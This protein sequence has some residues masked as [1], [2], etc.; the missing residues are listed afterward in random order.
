MSTSQYCSGRNDQF[1]LPVRSESNNVTSRPNRYWQLCCCRRLEMRSM[2]LIKPDCFTHTGFIW[3]FT[4]AALY[5]VPALGYESL[6]TTLQH[7]SNWHSEQIPS[8][9]LS[10]VKLSHSVKVTEG[11]GSW[12]V[13][14]FSDSFLQMTA[15][16]SIWRA[17]SSNKRHFLELFLYT[18]HCWCL[19]VLQSTNVIRVLFFLFSNTTETFLS[20]DWWGEVV[21]ERVTRLRLFNT[22]ISNW[23]AAERYINSCVI[24]LSQAQSTTHTPLWTLSISRLLDS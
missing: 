2:S 1:L 20:T 23:G 16:L 24:T 21:F 19:S 6:S 22:S 8:K 17:T 11:F 18:T 3:I 14:M 9:H 7:N 10:F 13:Y 15:V 12:N 5:S 4:F